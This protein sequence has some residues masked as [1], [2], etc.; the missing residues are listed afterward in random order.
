MQII[1]QKGRRWL[2][3]L[4]AV[5]MLFGLLPAS[6]LILPAQAAGGP[7]ATITLDKSDMETQPYDD[8]NMVSTN[9]SYNKKARM[10][11]FWMNVNG[12][13]IPGF[14]ADH[15]KELD[16]KKGRATWG[17]P[18]PLE[19]AV[20]PNGAPYSII[21][22]YVWWYYSGF[23]TSEYIKAN[24]NIDR[25]ECASDA[26]YEDK[27]GKWSE[28]NGFGYYAQ[29]STWTQKLNSAY[30]QCS[31]WMVGN[32]KITSLDSAA[33][34]K[35]AE[36]Y[37]HA[38]CAM[39]KHRYHMT[40]AQIKKEY[41]TNYDSAM[42]AARRIVENY[43]NGEYFN[44]FTDGL[45][46]YV[47][48]P[49]DGGRF[50]ADK[51]QPIIVAVRENENTESPYAWL[52][53]QKVDQDGQP[54]TGAKFGVY[55]DSS[56]SDESELGVFTTGSNGV[57][58][59]KVTWTALTASDTKRTVW[60]KELQGPSPEYQITQSPVQGT[61]DAN[62]HVDEAH[63]LL[64]R[65]GPWKN[66]VPKPGKSII[67]KVDENGIGIGPGTFHFSC[68]AEGMEFDVDFDES[69]NL[70]KEL[71]WWNP[72]L[73]NYIPEGTY[74]VTETKGPEG[75]V[76]DTSAK[77]IRLWTEIID[78]IKTP[79][80]SGPL[81]F[82]NHEKI[83]ITLEKRDESGKGL[84]GAV[85]AVYYNDEY[86]KDV[87]TGADGTFVLTGD[88]GEGLPDGV[89]TFIETKA[90]AGYVLPR[91]R[92]QEVVLCAAKDGPKNV[93]LSFTNYR[94]S[95]I[96]IKKVQTGTTSGL[97]G[98]TFEVKIDE[99]SIGTVG[100]TGP[101]GVI[102][103]DYSMYG[104]FLDDENKD[105]WVISVRE[106]IAPDGYMIDDTSWHSQV[107]R[108]GETLKEFLFEDE[109]PTTI[110]IKKVSANTDE[111]LAGATFEV[112]VEGEI[113]GTFGPTKEDG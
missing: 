78:D 103:L 23:Y 104:K 41:P 50:S 56:C 12:Q 106:V 113:I 82:V 43:N 90:P 26:D 9:A 100:P 105:S 83:R 84:P 107:L 86:L 6:G 111:P 48:T 70:T 4:L 87:E 32:G 36:S 76:I 99:Q 91:N 95:E 31:A 8:E 58:Y 40:T 45:K 30:P 68:L 27:V 1:K 33:M 54:L 3:G 108:Q 97:A 14:C 73:P 44:Q 39:Y 19:E 15:S 89:Y 80:N 18:V 62:V 61:V 22:P 42:S 102:Q 67:R 38:W 28:E 46:V 10:R 7:P 64:V 5:V 94:Y 93:I 25:N 79:K 34:D 69:G 72:A 98:A 47:Y 96:R 13:R 88:G 16:T 20:A 51:T 2:S 55:E 57:G 85:F 92:V 63:A 110:I 49:I 109:A 66:T 17:N 81:T 101:D 112:E 77:E 71:N 60:V 24:C 21:A 11:I 65:G 29:W 75:Y 74:Q 59:F 53:V 37:L 35:V 52:K